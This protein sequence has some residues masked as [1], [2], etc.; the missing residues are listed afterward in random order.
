MISGIMVS[1]WESDFVAFK[2][3]SGQWNVNL[4]AFLT[5]MSASFGFNLTP[6]RFSLQFIPENFNGASGQLPDIGTYTTYEVRQGSCSQGFLIAGNVIHAD[7]QNSTNGTIVR[8]DVE[9][10]RKDFLDQIKISSEDLGTNLPSG[11][12]SVARMYR[13]TTGFDDVSGISDSRVKEYRNISEL[14]CTYQQIYEAIVWARNNGDITFNP[15]GLPHPD[16]VAANTMGSLEPIRWKFNAQPLSEVISAIL[17]DTA[18]DWYWGMQDDAV[19]LVNRKVTFDVSE[20]SL[21]IQSLQ[22][23]SV[24]FRFGADVVQAPSKITVLGA[25][26]QGILNSTLLSSIDGIDNPSGSMVFRPAWSTIC[27]IR[28]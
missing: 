17:N 24:D 11:L 1:G 20:D 22:P 27:S 15:S 8:V 21:A 18:Y 26:Q 5:S 13:L 19:K 16:I 4:D 2:A 28:S 25:N 10:R 7:Y 23:D 14:G 12:V 9:D 3:P 6:H